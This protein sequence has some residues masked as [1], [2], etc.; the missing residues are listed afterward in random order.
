MYLKLASTSQPVNTSFYPDTGKD[1]HQI[2]TI[3][4]KRPQDLSQ[5]S[6]IVKKS[7]ENTYT[8]EERLY[9]ALALC[10]IKTSSVAMHITNEWRSRFFSQLDNLMDVENWEEDDKPITES[11]FTT[12]LRMIIYIK[13]ARRPG[14]GSTSKGNIIASWTKDTDRLTIECLPDDRV[15]WVLSCITDGVRE[16]AAGEVTLTRLQK[17]LSPYDTDRWFANEA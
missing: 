1:F 11:S 9:D 17:V 10:K 16:T 13:P 3:K 15:R 12:L 6:G 2:S 5:L 8:I 7:H 14:I 4:N